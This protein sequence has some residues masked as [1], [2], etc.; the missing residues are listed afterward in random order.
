MLMCYAHH[1][2]TNDVHKYTVAR[3]RDIKLAHERRFSAADRELRERIQKLKWTTLIGA[4]IVAGV[5]ID[6]I[7]HH[8][9]DTL[10][11]AAGSDDLRRKRL[12]SDLEQSLRYAPRGA[13]FWHSPADPDRDVA[14]QLLEV[15]QAAGWSIAELSEVPKFGPASVLSDRAGTMI[16]VIGDKNQVSNA[17]QAIFDFFEVCG[18]TA[19]DPNKDDLSSKGDRR[20]QFQIM[21]VI[22]KRQE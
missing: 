6:D 15:F 22:G 2:V 21:V 3:L 9:T 14:K 20:V 7:A 19:V 17:R 16:F 11:Y 13:V 5:A 4:G 12:H 18:F 10:G 1:Q 8:M